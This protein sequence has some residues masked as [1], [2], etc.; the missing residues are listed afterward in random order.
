MA[1]CQTIHPALSPTACQNQVKLTCDGQTGSWALWA[2]WTERIAPPNVAIRTDRRSAF[3]QDSASRRWYGIPEIKGHLE[4]GHVAKRIQLPRNA[5][6]DCPGWIGILEDFVAARLVAV[7]DG[8]WMLLE[9]S[10]RSQT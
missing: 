2:P 8:Q 4:G 6:V 10:W 1:H 5:P 7:W 9:T 3:R